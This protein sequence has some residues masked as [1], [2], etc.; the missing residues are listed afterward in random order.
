MGSRR[1]PADMVRAPIA[2]SR[3]PPDGWLVDRNG[4]TTSNPLDLYTDPP[5]ALM[6][7][8]AHKGCGLSSS[9]LPAAMR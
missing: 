3:R 2:P 8:G 4:R 7:F 6:P 9:R 5:S 1:F